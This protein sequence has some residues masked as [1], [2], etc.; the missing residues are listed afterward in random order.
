MID[1]RLQVGNL[2]LMK[3]TNLDEMEATADRSTD[4]LRVSRL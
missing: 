3:T 4:Q 1:K 2:E